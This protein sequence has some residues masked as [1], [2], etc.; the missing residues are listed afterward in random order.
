MA[1]RNS[2]IFYSSFQTA[3]ERLPSLEMKAAFYAAIVLYGLEGKEPDF[4]DF[5]DMERNFLLMAMDNIKPNIDAA[6]RRREANSANGK[7]GGNPNFKKGQRNPYY[8]EKKITQDNREITETLPKDKRVHKADIDKEIDNRNRSISLSAINTNCSTNNPPIA[9]GGYPAP[10][11][12]VSK[13]EEEVQRGG[14]TAL[15]PTL[16]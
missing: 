12:A 3:A 1:I 15:P 9:G 2:F 14:G 10:A 7:K 5:P 6:E 8:S 4:A 11:P 16:K 13:P